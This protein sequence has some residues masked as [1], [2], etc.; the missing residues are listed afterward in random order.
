MEKFNKIF[1]V[2]LVKKK[3]KNFYCLGFFNIFY[4]K[5]FIDLT[6]CQNIFATLIF[7]CCGF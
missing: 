6:K 5:K 3:K 2:I 1:S 7:S 4:K